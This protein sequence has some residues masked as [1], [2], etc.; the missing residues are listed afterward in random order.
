[1]SVVTITLLTWT[2]AMNAPISFDLSIPDNVLRTRS[3]KPKSQFSLLDKL[4]LLDPHSPT[5]TT[6]R[7]VREFRHLFAFRTYD[8]ISTK[9]GE[10]P[11]AWRAHRGPIGEAEVIRHLLADRLAGRPP[12]WFGTRSFETS[13]FF[14]LDVD[15]DSHA[16]Q[17]PADAIGLR[18]V[19]LAPK[20]STLA[21]IKSKQIAATTKPSFT[22][23]CSKLEQA[24][25]RLA[26]DA[27]DT[28][29]VLVQRT[30][31][32][33]RHY[34]VFLDAPYRIS[35]IHDLLR[36]IGLLHTKG[37]TE[38]FP[39]VSHGCRLPFGCLPGT[40]HDPRAW[41]QFI[42]DFHNGRIVRHSLGNLY[43]RLDRHQFTQWKRLKSQR[44]KAADHP[45][46]CNTLRIGVPRRHETQTVADSPAANSRYLELIQ[47]IKC[48]ADADQLLALGIQLPGTRT[49]A[50]KQLAAHLIWF[51]GMTSDDA[52]TFLSGWAM[53]PRHASKDIADDLTHGTA[54]VAKHIATMCRWYEAKKATSENIPTDADSTREFAP[55]EL[56]ALHSHLADLSPDDRAHQA[57]FLL[58]FLRFA[59]LHG[60][61]DSNG[62]G[63][64]ASPAIRQ[65]IRRW[66]GC[67]HM[68]YATR[69][70]HAISGGGMEL[71]KEAWHRPNGSGRART[72]RLSVPVVPD[73]KWVM[74]YEAAFNFLMQLEPECSSS[75]PMNILSPWTEEE[76]P[77]ADHNDRTDPGYPTDS[78]RGAFPAPL[79]P[80]SAGT[81]LD[82]GPRQCQ[83]QP[84]AAPG[85]YCGTS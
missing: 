75:E 46:A 13:T 84:Y 65:V 28:Y 67:H 7:R 40:P 9:P 1:V 25:R 79:S 10:G 16:V 31:R 55:Q 51:R 58:H 20:G 34:Y 52:T 61:A 32:G 60:S 45:K 68:N 26:I 50:L 70:S 23:R 21:P 81:R 62:S 5:D 80:S 33:G 35:Q 17:L 39:S 57:H 71:V 53:S 77:H 38:F 41:I 4:A 64:L 43:E 37:Q 27:H 56:K 42:D 78:E 83:P 59:K 74:T 22:D 49:Q 3:G 2:H 30:P 18:A 11:R 47:A 85:L 29:Q 82:S 12:V 14:C 24:L 19:T 69:L 8:G 76:T 44:R 6:L 15:A 63:W 54:A 66:P 73:N 36:A 72:Y 48:K